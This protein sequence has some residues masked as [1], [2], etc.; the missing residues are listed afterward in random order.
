[1]RTW[2]RRSILVLAFLMATLAV[3]SAV[4]VVMFK[5]DPAWYTG[6]ASPMSAEQ[7]RALAQSAENKLIE[8]Q[9][10]AAELRADL[11]RA[12]R[13]Q[14]RGKT[15]LPATRAGG[16]HVIQVSD[17]ELNALFEKWSTLYGWR[18]K[19]AAY[20]EDPQ[21]IVQDGHLVFAGRL[22]ELGAVASFTFQPQIDDQGRLHFDLVSVMGGR[23]PLPDMVWAHWRTQIVQSLRRHYPEWSAGAKIDPAGSANFAATAATLSRLVFAIAEHQ[24]A[25]PVLFL[26]IADH[27]QT[28]PVRVTSITLSGGQV[29]MQVQPLTAAERQSLLDRIREPTGSDQAL[30]QK[31]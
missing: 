13:S 21:V 7:R 5:S 2:V 17:Q 25:D 11:V 6:K 10:W 15:T 20:L 27:G 18:G 4:G 26:P 31:R 23:L 30:G 19:Y 8:A 22:K 28:V 3:L 16:T 9:N 29:S 14:E 1:M 24:S 12:A